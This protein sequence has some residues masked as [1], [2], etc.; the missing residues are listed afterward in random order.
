MPSENVLSADNQQGRVRSR[1]QPWYVCGLVDGEGSFHIAL[2]KDVRMK[3]GIKAIPEFHVSQRVSSRHV[4]DELIRFFNCGYVKE[5]HHTN[6]KDVTYVYVVRDRKDLLTRIIPFFEKYQLQTEKRND[7]R[8]FAKIVRL[9]EQRLHRDERGMQQ[10]IT[11]AYTM[12]GAGRYR[13][14]S[15]ETLM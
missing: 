13:K 11:L 14:R 2:Y 4:L 5:N 10:I 15:K 12:N 8:I 7:A 9:M 3:V 1:F 6:P